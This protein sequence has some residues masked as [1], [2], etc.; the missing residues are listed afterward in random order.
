MKGKHGMTAATRAGEPG[1]ATGAGVDR[2]RLSGPMVFLTWVVAAGWL[3]LA[4]G[5]FVAL[6]RPWGIVLGL[7]GLVGAA[8]TGWLARSMVV[9]WDA[10]GLVL[11]GRGRTV[12]DDIERL[13]VQPG[14]V[15]VPMV[16]LRQGRGLVDVPLDGLAWFGRAGRTASRLAG[17]VAE[18]GDL[19]EVS[20]RGR[21]GAPGR[22]ALG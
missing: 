12:W 5:S 10:D 2:G 4:I 22:R 13:E 1:G 21:A 6:G 7:V 19:P 17:R 8:G 11:P 15:S 20:V 14:F 3:A 9:R 16:A 18:A